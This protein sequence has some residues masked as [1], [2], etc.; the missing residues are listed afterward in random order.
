MKIVFLAIL[1]MGLAYSQQYSNDILLTKESNSIDGSGFASYETDMLGISIDYPINWNIVEQNDSTIFSP[2]INGS[3]TPHVT[4]QTRNSHINETFAQYLNHYV[5]VSSKEGYHN[6]RIINASSDASLGGLPAYVIF[7]Q[8]TE[9]Y[10]DTYSIRKQ[11]EIGT[12]VENSKVY[13]IK[14]DADINDYPTYLPYVKE[15]IQSFKVLSDS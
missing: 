3:L 11:L 10:M 13:S 9:P 5:I 2:L 15:M 4:L 6:F 8:Y 14:Y 1:A 7:F 12:I